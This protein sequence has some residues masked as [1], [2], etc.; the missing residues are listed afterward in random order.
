MSHLDHSHLFTVR[1][2]PD[3]GAG[4]GTGWRGRATHVLSGETQHFRDWP[5]LLD[6]L[7]A[8][9]VGQPII[10]AHTTP[11]SGDDEMKD[12]KGAQRHCLMI[13]HEA[14]EGTPGSAIIWYLDWLDDQGVPHSQQLDDHYQG[15]KQLGSDGWR[16]VQVIERPAAEGV[17][18]G[19]VGPATHYYFTRPARAKG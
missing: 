13:S 5:A 9:L 17:Y 4:G 2:W 14:G 8:A 1:L 19:P 7:S 12:D 6:F 18:D 3:T 15:F 11:I 16:L 10:P